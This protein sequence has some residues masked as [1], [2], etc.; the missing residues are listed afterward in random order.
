MMINRREF[1]ETASAGLTV[2]AL[3]QGV[4]AQD[5]SDPLGV[6]DDFPVV[7]TGT[8][9][10]APYITPSPRTATEAVSQ[11]NH[12]K[13]RQPAPLGAMLEQK[14]SVRNRFAKLVNASPQE[15]GFLSAT[16]DGENTIAHALDLKAGDNVVLDELH[17]STSYILYRHLEQE[18]G[19]ELRIAKAV[20]GA[21]P[22]TAFE[23]LVDDRTRLISVAWVAHQ[24]GFL[25]D[26]DGL[27]D[28]AHSKGA[29]LY[30]DAIQAA[31]MV[32]IDVQKTPIDCFASGTYKWL[33]GGYGIAPCFVRESILDR[34]PPDR[35]G[36]LQVKR[37][38]PNYQY[39]FHTGARKLEYA[40][41][42]FAA[43]YELGAGLEYLERIGIDRIHAHGV[44]LAQRVRQGLV[45]LGL[46]PVTPEGNQTA[47]VAFENPIDSEVA[48]QLFDEANIQ[49]TFREGGRQIR[50]GAALFNTESDID[51][52]LETAARLV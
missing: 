36:F 47:I 14:E 27:A 19:I 44:A 41:P 18:L 24:N 4:Q 30:A 42:A 20:A 48:T 32:P 10:N 31:G 13:A 34:V 25:H 52:F 3:G 6:R 22:V 33:L 12:A 16:S 11:F 7:E 23:P 1:L 2:T 5:G 17:F 26:V 39:E 45:E 35:R 38:L 49:L 15:I 50:V 21:V 51:I 46:R 40:T 9:L 43:F 28:L 37:E 8:Y 29:Y